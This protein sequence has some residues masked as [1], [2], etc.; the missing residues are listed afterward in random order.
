MVMFVLCEAPIGAATYNDTLQSKTV[1]I[2]FTVEV[3][4]EAIDY[5][6][7]IVLNVEQTFPHTKK[8]NI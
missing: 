4:N 3:M 8:R 1:L 5:N 2:Y 6:N 7:L